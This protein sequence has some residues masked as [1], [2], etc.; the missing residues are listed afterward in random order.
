VLAVGPDYP[1]AFCEAIGFRPLGDL[2]VRVDMLERFTA[3]VRQAARSGAFAVTP[4]LRE[5]LGLGPD[6]TGHLLLALGYRSEVTEHGPLYRTAERTPRRRRP[7][8]SARDASPF[9]VLKSLVR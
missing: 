3:L 5:P 4:A 2:A 9:A 8:A 7:G 6:Q 1:A